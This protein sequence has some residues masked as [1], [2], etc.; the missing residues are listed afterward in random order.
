MAD[1]IE[2][3]PY[4]AN[5]LPRAGSSVSLSQSQINNRAAWFALETEVGF[6][7]IPRVRYSST[8][9]YITDFFI[10]NN[11]EFTAQNVI[12]LAPIIKMYAT[13]KIKSPNLT[14]AQFKNQI[15]EY[16]R[17][18]TG[19]QD[20]FLNGVLTKL[21]T[22]LPDQQ[23][24]PER[25][26]NSVVSGDQSKAE[27]Y[28][29]FKALNDKW[30]AGGD[31]K[32]KTLFED[33]L[34]LD[35]ASRNIG[36]TLLID[37]FD[38]KNI[39][40]QN[41]LN[42][43]MSV[44]TFISSLMIKNNFTIMNLPAYVNFYNVQ[45]VDGLSTARAEGS[46]EFANNMWG[47]FLDVDYRKSGPKMICFY[48]GKPSQYLDLPKGNFRFR[49]DSFEMRKASENPLIENQKGKKDWAVSNKCVGFNVDMGIRNQNVFYSFAVAQ[50]N[51]IATSESINTL[52]NMVDQSSGRAVATQNVSLYNLYKQRSYKCT[53]T[54]L[55]NALIQPTMYFNLQHIPMFN[56]PYMITDVSH[57]IQPGNFQTVF[58][59][60]RQ[61]IYD[62]PAIDNFI[63][64]INQNLLTKIEDLLKINKEQVYVTGTTN[65]VNASQVVQK[66]DNTL[67]TTNSC[68]GKLAPVYLN[69]TPAYTSV[70]GTST[71]VTQ[72]E[73]ASA[74]KRLIPQ[75][76]VLRAAIYSISYA[77][78]FQRATNSKLGSFNGWNNNLATI[79]L[80]T[81]P[82][83]TVVYFTKTYSCVNIKT[84]PS[85]SSSL[86]IAHFDT[87]DNFIKFMESRLSG[88]VN[89]ILDIGLAKYY[90]CHW[91]NPGVSEEYYDSNVGQF[92]QIKDTLYQAL[93]SAVEVGLVEKN[94]SLDIKEKVKEVES[95]GKTPG[96][97]P[98]PSPIPS[99]PGKTC[100]PPVITTF[101]PSA[102]FTGTIVQLNGRHFKS[103]KTLK[104]IGKEVPTKD[105]TVLNEQLLTFI[106][107][108][109]ELADGQQTKTGKIEITTD[110]GTVQSNFTFTFNKALEGVVTSSPGGY[111][112][113]TTQQQTTVAQQDAVA[114]NNNPQEKGPIPLSTTVNTKDAY[115]GNEKLTVIV[116]PDPNVGVWKIDS[117]PKFSYNLYLVKLGSNNQKV[118]EKVDESFSDIGLV[119][120]VSEDGQTFSIDKQSFID[121]EFDSAVEDYPSDEIVIETEITLLARPADREKYPQYV[122][123][124]YNFKIIVPPTSVD[125][126][127]GSIVFIT[128]TDDVN[129]PN[130][131]GS[132]YF[133]IKKENGGYIVYKFDCTTCDIVDFQV[134][135][136]KNQSQIQSITTTSD[137][138]TKYQRVI[139][140]NNKGEFILQVKYENSGSTKKYTVNSVPFIL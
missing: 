131:S 85:T 66:A 108:G 75:N 19:I 17:R 102:G 53:I 50:D 70:N 140:V 55:G 89:R 115:G 24:L 83:A 134:V 38:L 111:Q 22:V 105:I 25:V 76:P 37:I 86:P 82:G 40:N 65:S 27:T 72:S 51:G 63:Q 61:G 123:K 136:A 137:S 129:I 48:A 139:Q 67:D 36:D 10:D 60:T 96:V 12:L 103:L 45:D 2:F 100:P 99:N 16:L 98:T 15:S 14:V 20:N 23:Q 18:E 113:T 41:S 90:I 133:S 93:A 104:V 87:L 109:L 88:N 47:T 91:S 35:R 94:L 132:E 119:G 126:V 57:S 128:N 92:K 52:L 49:D 80:D 4:V 26:I 29:V 46:T 33:I 116:N 42:Q 11:I 7:T 21:R 34:F 1:P 68:V 31:Y 121:A 43:A 110:Y 69:A 56:G 138:G 64:S 32:T 122:T 78:T 3:Q 97:T 6:S 81:D 28:E 54:S 130:Y 125:P 124:E 9:S 62:L 5:S 127:N 95:K 39:L 74:L 118:L 71:N 13:Q 30:I 135:S 120:F 117:Q 59:G 44:F 107:P 8:G 84:N 114:V 101:S 112:N 77:R 106:L 73:F 79:T 58:N